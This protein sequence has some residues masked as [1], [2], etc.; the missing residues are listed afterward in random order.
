MK[1]KMLFLKQNTGGEIMI[2]SLLV[3]I[4]TLFVLVF[5]IALGLVFYQ[6][7]NVQYVADAVAEN[8]A[9]SYGY[10]NLDGT[11]FVLTKDDVTKR[12]VC[13]Y[14]LGNS[15]T[16]ENAKELG[17][18]LGSR[19]FRLT[20]LA[21]PEDSEEITVTVESDSL[22]RRHVEIEVEAAYKMY[23]SEGLRVFKFGEQYHYQA[24]SVAEC[25]DPSALGSTIMFAKNGPNIIV[26]D[27]KALSSLG[28]WI[29]AL[30][31][32]FSS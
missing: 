12:R 16:I 15:K 28:K 9:L 27:S 20:N 6:Q 7:W 4:P 8:V 11:S 17:E 24:T 29:G 3:F 30:K 2:E 10:D 25:I 22:G 19:L 5:L 32:L 23:F 18:N 1:N 21:K 26:G 14:S 31:E 13:R